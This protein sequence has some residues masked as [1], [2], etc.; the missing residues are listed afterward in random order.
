MIHGERLISMKVL[1]ID[2][3]L[4]AQT[5]NGRAVRALISELRELDINVIESTSADDGQ[6]V[7]LSDPSVQGIL[8]DWTLSDNDI[9]HDKAKALLRLIRARNAH[10]PDFLL[11]QRGESASLT[12]GVMRNVDELI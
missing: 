2:D 9:A 8:L 4:T 6:S 11:V 12:A 3:E 7:V 5:A 1:I 10:V